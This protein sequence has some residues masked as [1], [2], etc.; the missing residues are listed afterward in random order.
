[1]ADNR[2]Q[3]SVAL[4]DGRPE[5]LV[6]LRDGGRP[7]LFCVHP[8]SGSAY[9]YRGLA[10]RLPAEQP[11]YGIEA[12]GFDN[13][14]APVASLPRLADE[15]TAMLRAFAPGQRYHLLGW[16]LGGTI[17]FEIAKRLRLAGEEVAALILVD[18]PVPRVLPLPPEREIM[19]GFVN[20]M[21]GTSEEEAAPHAKVFFDNL[22]EDIDP[23]RAF[24]LVEAANILP[25]EMDALMLAEQYAVFRALL[26]GFNSVEVTGSFDAAALHILAELSP[27]REMDWSRAL[28]RLREMTLP[29]TH[30]SI[31]TGQRL[32]MM[33]EI[34]QSMLDAG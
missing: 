27:R 20:D 17:A 33:S 29:G 16:S 8:I 2:A 1:V 15:Y 24:A 3:A 4:S 12:P 23:G 21:M 9:A 14:R 5:L 6:R 11:V 30:Y 22:P 18:A 10:G 19:L 26:D 7:A 32:A 28:P 25:D 31:W 13:D 34:V